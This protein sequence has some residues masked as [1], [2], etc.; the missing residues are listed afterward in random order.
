MA[1]FDILQ[2][3]LSVKL[4]S[5]SFLMSIT[6]WKSVSTRDINAKTREI[7]NIWQIFNNYFDL[8]ARP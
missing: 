2:S 1:D 6:N 3:S 4:E 5:N 7:D 8:K